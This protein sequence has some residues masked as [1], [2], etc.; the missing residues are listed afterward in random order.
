MKIDRIFVDGKVETIK[1][2]D[3]EH[4]CLVNDVLVAWTHENDGVRFPER[5]QL[6]AGYRWDGAS[7]P[8]FIGWL[9]PRGGVFLLASAVHDYAFKTRFPVW[10]GRIS[11]KHA[12]LLFL[13]MMRWLAADRVTAGWKAWAQVLLAETMYR[14]VRWFGEP[15]WDRHDAEF[16]KAK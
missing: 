1:E 15:T 5:V 14:A 10:G 3:G 8:D 11:R 2:P 4:W 6:K 12:D 7:R 9:I 16:R 13:A